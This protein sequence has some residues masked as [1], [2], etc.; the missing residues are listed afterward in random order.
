MAMGRGMALSAGSLA[1]EPMTDQELRERALSYATNLDR[2]GSMS[3]EE[4][5]QTAERLYAFLKGEGQND[6]ADAGES[7]TEFAS[8]KNGQS[9][10]PYFGDE[11][12]PD[13]MDRWSRNERLYRRLRDEGLWVTRIHSPEELGGA[14]CLMVSAERPRTLPQQDQG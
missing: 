13:H 8:A 1:R 3:V 10:G 5:A 11:A 12:P 4:I 7:S 2:D 14:E 6:S 9:A